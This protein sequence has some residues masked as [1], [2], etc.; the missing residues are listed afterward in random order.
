V[1]GEEAADV[2]VVA[3][4]HLARVFQ[5]SYARWMRA[6][7]DF[8]SHR[9]ARKLL[10]EFLDTNNGVSEEDRED[11]EREIEAEDKYAEIALDD[12]GRNYLYLR[13]LE[14]EIT[15]VL[16]RR[17]EWRTDP[18]SVNAVQESEMRCSE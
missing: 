14:Q 18:E 7:A 12:L 13:R 17:W 11:I 5:E 6:W 8:Q 3:I 16:G 9:K 10:R 4:K 1:G 2:R 15:K